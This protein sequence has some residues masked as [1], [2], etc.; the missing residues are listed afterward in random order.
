MAAAKYYLYKDKNRTLRQI[1]QDEGSPVCYNT[2]STRIRRG[3][4][5]KKALKPRN[6]PVHD[7]WLKAGKPIR[8]ST[9]YGRLH[10]GWTLE[11]SLSEPLH[12]QKNA[13][14]VIDPGAGLTDK[15][16]KFYG[17]L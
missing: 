2:F 12:R 8:L 1:L 11:K 9:L 4:T 16:K 10:R 15:K 5:I 3:L 7:A 14:K 17:L 6:G 13:E